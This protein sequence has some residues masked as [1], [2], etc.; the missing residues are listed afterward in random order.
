[1]KKFALSLSFKDGNVTRNGWVKHLSE[2]AESA[3]EVLVRAAKAVPG[4]IAHDRVIEVQPNPVE[5]G[6]YESTGV[7]Y[8]L[9]RGDQTFETYFCKLSQL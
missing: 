5:H 3:E 4:Y 9:S 2:T 8:Q 7:H 6:A 1:M